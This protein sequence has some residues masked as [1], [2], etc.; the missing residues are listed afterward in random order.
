MME[1]WWKEILAAL[2]HCVALAYSS[3]KMGKSENKHPRD[4]SEF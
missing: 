3:D 2:P 4:E 1:C